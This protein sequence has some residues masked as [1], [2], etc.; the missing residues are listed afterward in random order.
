MTTF[1]GPALLATMT[2][3]RMQGVH[4]LR[5]VLQGDSIDIFQREAEARATS[6]Q[7][8][9][10]SGQMMEAASV[11]ALPTQIT[12]QDQRDALTNRLI[13][14][15]ALHPEY[16]CFVDARTAN[17]SGIQQ[18]K[19]L[20]QV[21]Y[22]LSPFWSRIKL[23]HSLPAE[24]DFVDKFVTR[25]TSS[26]KPKAETLKH[27]KLL[28]QITRLGY[29]LD[30]PCIKGI[31]FRFSAQL[32]K[33]RDQLNKYYARMVKQAQ[34][35]QSLKSRTSISSARHDKAAFALP[36]RTSSTPGLKYGP[37]LQMAIYNLNATLA[38][39]GM[40]DCAVAAVK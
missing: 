21:L 3:A 26:H 22:Y 4:S 28:Q 9:T 11:R 10:I 30:T 25:S 37:G 35:N 31:G 12:V 5:L 29:A 8:T 40:I 2:D 1:R 19:R 32:S 16:G 20:G 6:S 33:L 24:L 27:D 34:L 18:F 13:D 15:F 36:K 7:P 38:T 14:E 23:S 39:S 17:T